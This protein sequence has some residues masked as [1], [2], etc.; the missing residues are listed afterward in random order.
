M[1]F[2]T[3]IIL[4]AAIVSAVAANGQIKVFESDNCS[5]GALVFNEAPP[6]SHNGGFVAI[7]G[8]NDSVFVT[9]VD[10]GYSCENGFGVI[11]V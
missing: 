9:G 8:V 3:F 4:M 6:P 10:S 5:G 7:D 1:K 2:A 11:P